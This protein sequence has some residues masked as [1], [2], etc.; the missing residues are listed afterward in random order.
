MLFI[1]IINSAFIHNVLTLNNILDTGQPVCNR[2]TGFLPH[3]KTFVKK[4]MTATEID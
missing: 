2:T 4:K 3:K 1:I